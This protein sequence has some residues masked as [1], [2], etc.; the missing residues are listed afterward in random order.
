MPKR[1]L[2]TAE[3]AEM[4]AMSPEWVREHAA[5]LGAMRLGDG[6]KGHLRF[7]EERVLAA[8]EKRRVAAAQPQTPRAR[9]GRRPQ[10]HDDVELLK[11]PRWAQDAEPRPKRCR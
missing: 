4:L 1:F 10:P 8:M 3:V 9:P 6:P 5:E 2:T 11:L 7:D